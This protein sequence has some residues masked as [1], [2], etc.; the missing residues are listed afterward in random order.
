MGLGSDGHTA[1]LFPGQAQQ[2]AQEG[3]TLAVTADYDGR[4]S[5]RVTLTPPVFNDC[6]LLVFLVVGERKAGAVA[7]VLG[8]APDPAS[9]LPAARL[10]PTAGAI[11][12]LLDEAAA[13]KLGSVPLTRHT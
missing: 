11:V 7:R 2:D 13:A 10:W 4:P 3:P 9:A 6:R 12:W 8:S 1:S 5:Q